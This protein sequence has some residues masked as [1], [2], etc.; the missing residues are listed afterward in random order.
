MTKKVFLT[1]VI[2]FLSLSNNIF[3]QTQLVMNQTAQK[4]Y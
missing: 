1:I 4:E 3:A 2:I